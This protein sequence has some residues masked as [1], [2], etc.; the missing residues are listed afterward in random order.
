MEALANTKRSS[1]RIE[2]LK[3]SQEEKDRLLALQVRNQISVGCMASSGGPAERRCVK[4]T[5]APS[6]IYFFI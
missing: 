6:F 4:N 3:K 1:S 2:T 5:P